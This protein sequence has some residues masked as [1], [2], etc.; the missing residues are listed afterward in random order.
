MTAL[1]GLISLQLVSHIDNGQQISNTIH[2]SDETAGS[3]PDLTH[4]QGVVEEFA[5]L[6]VTPYKNLLTTADTFDTIIGKQVADPLSVPPDVVLEYQHTVGGAGTRT[7]PA[8]NRGPDQLCGLVGFYTPNASRRFRGHNFM[9]PLHDNTQLQG[10]ALSPTGSYYIAMGGWVTFL[11]T[12]LVN[13]TTRWTGSH[14]GAYSIVIYSKRAA[15]T[16]QPSVANCSAIL[17]STQTRWLRSR[18][19]GTI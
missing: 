14:L 16:G 8:A 19:R 15:Q 10:E 7:F 2:V 9:P 1:A 12:G 17:R 13:A 3:P 5:A 4:L 11:Q 18:A 6:A